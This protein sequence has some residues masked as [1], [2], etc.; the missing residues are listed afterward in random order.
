MRIVAAAVVLCALVF[1]ALAADAEGTVT[2]V[3]QE[4][5]TITLENGQTYKLP[6]EMDASVIEPG[7]DV[8][9]AYRDVENGEKQITDMVLP[10]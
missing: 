3:D 9:I 1:P 8:V 4:N 6:A 10:E 7:M 2:K 5:L